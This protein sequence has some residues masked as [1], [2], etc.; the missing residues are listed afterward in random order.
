[1]VVTQQS[2]QSLIL[3]VMERIR[4]CSAAMRPILRH[5][6]QRKDTEMEHACRQYTAPAQYLRCGA[7]GILSAFVLWA[8]CQQTSVTG[9]QTIW[10]SDSDMQF[11]IIIVLRIKSTRSNI[12]GEREKRNKAKKYQHSGVQFE[13]TMKTRLAPALVVNY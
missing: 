2:H 1:M 12:Q 8:V 6:R 9:L 11:L 4:G 7:G 10:K 3:A 5:Y 13:T